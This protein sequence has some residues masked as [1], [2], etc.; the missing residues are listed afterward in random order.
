M[1]CKKRTL[2]GIAFVL[3]AWMLAVASEAQQSP[4]AAATSIDP[5]IAAALKEIS[6]AQIQRNIETLVAFN[7]R[8]TLSA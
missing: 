4:Q 2:T 5:Q 3:A 7:T 8:Q 6:A 1:T